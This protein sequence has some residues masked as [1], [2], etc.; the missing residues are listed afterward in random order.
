MNSIINTSLD[1]TQMLHISANL[2]IAFLLAIPIAWER[3]TATR[4]VG[5]RTFP[6]VAMS[7]CAFVL[8]STEQ[9][10][11]FSDA[12]ARI[13][14][15]VITGIG[16]IGGGAILKTNGNVN[17]TATAAGIWSTGAAGTAVAFG[18]LEIAV[19][20]SAAAFLTL[21]LLAPVKKEL[22]KDE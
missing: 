14:Q 18:H 20:L 2:G 17:G 5:L 1:W 16:F 13:M 6:L 4:S 12:Q 10:G 19:V 8:V 15:G 22:N 11:E 9:L 3:E 21:R 7:S